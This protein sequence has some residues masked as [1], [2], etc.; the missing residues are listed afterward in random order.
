MKWYSSTSSILIFSSNCIKFFSYDAHSLN[1]LDE[2]VV[3]SIHVDPTHLDKYD[4]VVPGQFDTAIIQ[5]RADSNP[6]DVG[7]V[8][9]PNR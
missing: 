6:V 2:I 7:N 1:P 3:D 4:K 5:F 8:I 9:N